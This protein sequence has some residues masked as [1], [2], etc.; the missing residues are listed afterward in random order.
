MILPSYSKK[1]SISFFS[2]NGDFKHACGSEAGTN[3][4]IVGCSGSQV[5]CFDTWKECLRSLDNTK[6]CPSW[7]DES[8]RENLQNR[9]CECNYV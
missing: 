6:H 9:I 5:F 7:F 4:K 3:L 8:R 1:H 2:T